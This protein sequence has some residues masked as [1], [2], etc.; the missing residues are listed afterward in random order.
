MLGPKA[1]IWSHLVG[2]QP[3]G[4]ESAIFFA[5]YLLFQENLKV[6]IDFYSIWYKDTQ[7]QHKLSFTE[8]FT[9]PFLI[10][11]FF[12]LLCEK[13]IISHCFPALE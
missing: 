1:D 10:N 2:R 13:C 6:V 8:D 11:I 7:S 12:S 4:R 9:L 5:L 3:T